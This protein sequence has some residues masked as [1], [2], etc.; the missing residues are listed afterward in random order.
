[1]LARQPFMGEEENVANVGFVEIEQFVA[2][3]CKTDQGRPEG[4]LF[5]EL[6]SILV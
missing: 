2:T 3:A 5:D 6:Q 4:R 1:M